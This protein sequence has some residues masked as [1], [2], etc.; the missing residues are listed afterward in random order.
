MLL[1]QLLSLCLPPQAYGTIPS[2]R[3]D[4]LLCV[5]SFNSEIFLLNNCDNKVVVAP[6]HLFKE[7]KQIKI[8]EIM[9][10]APE[11]KSLLHRTLTKKIRITYFSRIIENRF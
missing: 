5:T 9:L 7:K 6:N 8:Y 11:I 10:L 1:V 2:L 4:S 3:F